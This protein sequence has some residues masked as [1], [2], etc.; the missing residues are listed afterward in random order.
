MTASTLLRMKKVM[1]T[2]MS[3]LLASLLVITISSC[4]A[5]NDTIP[6]VIWHGMGKIA[7]EIL[8]EILK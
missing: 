4:T 6:A 2:Q 7:V 3:Y 1:A 8:T 5:S